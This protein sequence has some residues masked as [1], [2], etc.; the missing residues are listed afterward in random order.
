MTVLSHDLVWKTNGISVTIYGFV[1]LLALIASINFANA[2]DL[3][4]LK[5]YHVWLPMTGFTDDH[6]EDA[7]K[8]GYD[9]VMLKIAPPLSQDETAVDFQAADQLVDR[10]TAKGMN[11]IIVI[12]GWVGLGNGR[13]WDTSE[14]GEKIMNRLDP[15][16]DE[17]M[18]RVEWYYR[19]IIE[20]YAQNPKVVAFVP[21]WGIYGEAGFTSFSAG[22][23]L[24]ALAKFNEWRAT[25]GLPPMGSLPTR[26]AGPN[27]EFNRFIRFRFEYIERAFDRM[28]ARLKRFARGRP[29]GMWQELYPVIGYLW[30]MVEVPSAD[31]ALY[32]A[33]LT[34]Q[35]CHHPEKSLAETMGFR[36]RC[37]S[38]EDYK[39]Y[40][41]PLLARRRGE[42]G[43]FMGCQLTNDYAKNYGWTEDFARSVGFDRWEDDFGPHLKRLLD[44]PLESPQRD[45]LLVYPTYTASALSDSP[46]HFADTE[47]I[48][49]LL[50][51][52]GVQFAR[53]GTPRLD[54]M[55]INQ[56]DRFK[57][58]IVPESDYLLA[59]TY[60]KLLS[61]KAKIV[62]TGCF[63]KAFDG[64][65]LPIGAS[66]DIAGMVIQYN[67]RPAGRVEINAGGVLTRGLLDILKRLSVVLPEDESFQFENPGS[68]VQSVMTCDGRPVV[69][70]LQT[71]IANYQK[72]LLLIH[73]H[74]F[75]S[76]CWN[77]KRVPPQLTGSAD[78]S[79]NEVD[80]WGPY[81]SAH[82][83]NE[84]T[85]AFMRNVLDWAG[86]DYRVPDPKPRSL[87]PYLGDH[88]E[89]VSISANLVYNNTAVPQDITVRLPFKPVGV[90]S[91]KVG[92]RYE[93]TFS[94]PPFSFIVLRWQNE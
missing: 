73:G 80:L 11:V 56:M 51:M 41:L 10:V 74:L 62:L 68:G 9:T 63:G 6:L 53:C 20:H 37:K 50:R 34:Y 16:W 77:P 49:V 87:C 30:N 3:S 84:F 54:K 78:Q 13:F 66:R 75:A 88:M 91:R 27:T 79:A 26:D 70:L 17:A 71:N 92:T 52:F 5:A 76:A 93:A 29:V 25:L 60:Q 33:G 42:G 85:T 38:A 90:E 36:Y 35:A 43:R 4:P 82:A 23:S 69:T 58:I 47:I 22:R 48:E 45:V 39:N 40:Y 81:D 21:T 7:R 83:Q 94:V 31:F 65:Q 8:A 28:I 12:L 67:L 46:V 44:A 15:F 14:N 2:Q 86:V 89:Q 32:E 55:P 19:T 24:H 61:T 59:A 57:L 64:D 72:E 1:T 18:D